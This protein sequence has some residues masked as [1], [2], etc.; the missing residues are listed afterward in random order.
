MT[1]TLQ[2]SQLLRIKC[3]SAVCLMLQSH[4][5]KQWLK[6]LA[7]PQLLWQCAMNLQSCC[8][9][10][11][12][13]WRWEWGLQSLTVSCCFQ[14]D[15]GPSGRQ[16]N[17]SDTESGSISVQLNKVNLAIVCDIMAI[18]SFPYE[19]FYVRCALKIII[20]LFIILVYVSSLLIFEAEVWPTSF[21]PCN[22]PFWEYLLG[23][24]VAVE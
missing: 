4:Q 13:L 11:W 9:W 19:S 5:R 20:D 16:K 10:K 23:Q 22:I 8:F 3:F 6:T 14:S 1:K 15:F 17:S 21:S 12:F 24:R 18:N 7:Q 2:Q